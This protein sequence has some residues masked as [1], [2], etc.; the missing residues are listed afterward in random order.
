[1]REA[2]EFEWF[3]DWVHQYL[4]LTLTVTTNRSVDAILRCFRADP[5]PGQPLTWLEAAELE[6]AGE[7]F[8]PPSPASIELL[9]KHGRTPG[10]IRHPA[11]PP[12]RPPP[13]IL[14]VGTLGEWTTV[15]EQFSTRGAAFDV[16]RATSAGECKSV[17]YCYTQTVVSLLYAS[18]GE[19]VSGFDTTVPTIRWG[20]NPSYFDEP[21][22][23]A[24]G[25]LRAVSPAEIAEILDNEFDLT[26]E[27]AA[28]EGP[29]LAAT[30]RP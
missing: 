13:Q 26:I 6:D 10:D 11:P 17:V 23:R 22:A 24:V 25:S 1:M 9:N 28:L 18:D 12:R 29:L 30:L 8:A 19:L 4:G 14:R 7:S 21:L 3:T 27:R 20:S 16:L 5:Y 2:V 15:I